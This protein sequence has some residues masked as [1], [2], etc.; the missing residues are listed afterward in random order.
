MSFKDRY[1]GE[2]LETKDYGKYEILECKAW[3]NI[4]I[5]FLDTGYTTKT[6]QGN[7]KDGVIKD[8]LRPSV[9]GVGYYGIPK[10]DVFHPATS[11]WLDVMKRCYD[12]SRLEKA[13]ETSNM[14]VQWHNYLNFRDWV[15]AQKGFGVKGWELDKDLLIKGNTLYCPESCVFLPK[16]V[17]AAL[18]KR[19]NCRGDYPIGVVINKA[20]TKFEAW[21]GDGTASKYLGVYE[22]P[23][24]AFLAYKSKKEEFLKGLAN[25]YKE[26]LDPRAYEALM[27]YEVEI[28]D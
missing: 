27:N 1:V 15:V 4:T 13:Y 16:S 23:K 7:I 8:Y 22:T 20:K 5:R 26:L 10:A 3:D 12:E 6:R 17:N 11:K 2:I 19:Q 9:F 21:C 18:T 24:E 14:C 28:T 25:K